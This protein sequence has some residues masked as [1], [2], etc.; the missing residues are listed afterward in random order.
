DTELW[1]NITTSGAQ[2]YNDDV[3]LKGDVIATSTG[4]GD[5]TFAKTVDGT[6]LLDVR[7]GGLT[8]FAGE[9][10]GDEPLASL[11]TDAAGTTSLGGDVTTTGDQTYNDDVTVADG[12]MLTAGTDLR[13]GAGKTLTAD[14]DLTLEATNGEIGVAGAGTVGINMKVDDKTLKL[15][16]NGDLNMDVFSPVT[17]GE[18][19][20]LD[21]TSTARSVM[22]NVADIWQSI[23]AWAKQDISLSGKG[24][25][26]TDALYS[27]LGGIF[28]SSLL[29]SIDAMGDIQASGDIVLRSGLRFPPFFVLGGSITTK[30]P[31]Q[32]ANGNISL[33]AAR[34]DL[35]INK[36]LTANNGGVSLIAD[37]GRIYTPGY[38]ID[39]DPGSG[40]FLIDALNV[41]ISGYS[42]GTRGVPLPFGPGVAAI[43]IKSWAQLGLNTGAMLTANGTY[44][45]A[46]D[47][48]A[49]VAFIGGDPVDVAIYLGS[50]G[51]HSG[52]NVD[53]RSKVNAIGDNGAMVI[54]GYNAVTFLSAG[55]QF[56]ASTAFNTTNW[57]EVVSRISTT[58]DPEVIA[59]PPAP[60]LPYASDPDAIKSWYQGTYVLRGKTPLAEVLGSVV[61]VPLVPPTPLEPDIIREVEEI[62]ET[63]LMQWLAAEFNEPEIQTY[64]ADAYPQMLSTDLRPYKAAERLRNWALMLEDTEGTQ[65]AALAQAVSEV[66]PPDQPPD[67]LQ[68]AELARRFAEHVGDGTHYALARQW[69]DA[70]TEYVGILNTEI[71]WAADRSVTF[72]VRKYASGLG[73]DVRV[74]MFVQM[75]LE[76]TFGG[77]G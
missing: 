1:N 48:L 72:A 40:V 74:P 22:S 55:S 10:G 58:L 41:P 42:D 62:D 60:R 27:D 36:A 34:G 64:V 16:A 45:T 31:L 38:T 54:D 12:K 77:Q 21:A 32:S 44:S 4:D 19:T 70:L 13:F 51:F 9:V 47:D 53:V 30:E 73:E 35:I 8:N 25:I 76:R 49:G 11:A 50:S 5:I 15:T 67:E 29:G 68:M 14:G 71:G 26:K 57:L 61:P 28:I 69:L 6:K 63:A 17:N 46:V 56:E 18:H 33:W 3:D 59:G 52:I 39:I 23:K 65:V 7:T 24:T 66:V 43:V 75:H 37:S 20:D 2:T